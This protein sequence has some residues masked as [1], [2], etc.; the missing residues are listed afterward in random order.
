MGYIGIFL[1]KDMEEEAFS[2][3]KRFQEK[4]EFQIL[5]GTIPKLSP[6]EKE[7]RI[8][9]KVDE[10]AENFSHESASAIKNVFSD[11]LAGIHNRV[12]HELEELD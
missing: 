12:E 5:L 6:E 8:K 11:L 4:L 10:I 7:E 2:E 3:I 1:N 9:E